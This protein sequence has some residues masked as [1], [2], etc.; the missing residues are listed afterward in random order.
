MIRFAT[1][2]LQA[3]HE[4]HVAGRREEKRRGKLAV[5]LRAH[6]FEKCAHAVIASGGEGV[7]IA[8]AV[9]FMVSGAYAEAVAKIDAMPPWEPDPTQIGKAWRVLVGP[10]LADE[11][12]AMAAA[13]DTYGRP[14]IAAVPVEPAIGLFCIGGGSGSIRF[15]PLDDEGL[16]ST[17]YPRFDL[18]IEYVLEHGVRIS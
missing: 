10:G 11:I 6:A 18:P 2:E 5:A 9:D 13:P 3:E 8:C 16:R 12:R 7:C 1:P 17:R 4:K 14:V 15:T